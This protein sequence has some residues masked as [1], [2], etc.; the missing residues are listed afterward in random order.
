MSTLKTDT[1]QGSSVNDYAIHCNS[2]V[3]INVSGEFE[4]DANSQFT[5]PQGTTAERPSSPSTGMIR[6]NTTTNSLEVWDGSA[7]SDVIGGA[8]AS[9]GNYGVTTGG[10]GS[11]AAQAAISATQ[12]LADHP[13]TTDGAYYYFIPGTTNTIRLYTDMTRD[14]GGWV[15]IYTWNGHGKSNDTVY[16]ANDYNVS[17]LQNNGFDS[18]GT[19]SRPSRTTVNRIW[20]KSKFATR[21]HFKNDS[22]T[23]TSGVYF[24]CKI[25]RP[26]AMD[27]WSAQYHPMHW[28]D[29]NISGY[30][31]TGGGTYYTVAFVQ[32]INDPTLA[33]YNG[34]S[35][36]N[37]T[38]N[39]V[40]GGTGH[41]NNMGWWDRANVEAP[42]FGRIEVARHMGYF[43]DIN[44]GNQWLF[45]NN[46][47]DSR[48]GGNENRRAMVF[49]RW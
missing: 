28:S 11:S 15:K 47:G 19:N 16:N 26:E 38:T 2:G 30:Q 45:T 27:F 12:L 5:V 20:S 23:G 43:G 41:N 10:N 9:A 34:N 48:W 37:Q 3:D 14:G 40:T 29:H 18:Y 44:Q 31:A 8:G 24:Q 1:L 46:P 36:F 4:A 13:S 6:H 32:Q 35:N 17:N 49:L 33:N 25:S 39:Q 42:N 21:I 22:Y 7:W